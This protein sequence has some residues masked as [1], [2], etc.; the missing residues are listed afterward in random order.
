MIKINLIP[1]EQLKKVREV[2][3]KKPTLKLPKA[4][5]FLSVLILILT[6]GIVFFLN[7]QKDKKLKKLE[8]DIVRAEQQLRELE[9]EKKIVEEIEQQQK[10]LNEWITIVQTLNKGRSLYFHVMDELNSL[11]PEYIW[12]TLF[13]ENAQ[14]FKLQGKTFSNF[15][16]SNLMD[17]LQSSSYFDEV[18]LDEFK[19]TEEKEY[20]VISF[21]LSGLINLGG[22]K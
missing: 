21:Q 15:M 19:E 2:K 12:F 18:K 8:E 20:S 1:E 3:F 9:K 7:Y 4:D 22:E 5:M 6:I 14:R 16:I 13:E 17:R 11:K 10:E